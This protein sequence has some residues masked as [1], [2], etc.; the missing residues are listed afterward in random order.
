[1]V[2]LGAWRKY[3]FFFLSFRTTPM[4]YGHSQA[5]DELELQLL[6]YATATALR[7]LSRV[8]T[9]PQLMAMPD[10]WP[11]E[12]GQ[13]LNTHPHGYQSDS[14]PLCHHSNSAKNAFIRTHKIRFYFQG[15]VVEVVFVGANP[16]NSAEILV[17]TNYSF[18]KF[19]LFNLLF[20][21]V[22]L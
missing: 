20:T 22:S 7:D 3:F 21:W 14:F 1:M 2:Q 15:E 8:W 4:A 5:R 9:I 13:G 18:Y 12:Q 11:M 10:P 17:S 19:S 6:A 16:K